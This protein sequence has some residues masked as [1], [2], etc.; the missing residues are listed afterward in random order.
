MKILL[1]ALLVIAAAPAA[2]AGRLPI[3][4]VRMHA[5]G[6]ADQGPPPLG[7]RTPF[8]MAVWDQRTPLPRTVPGPLQA[9]PRAPIRFGRRPPTRR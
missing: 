3:L 7:M 5:L 6:A 4:D 8:P 9:P 1:A 2:V